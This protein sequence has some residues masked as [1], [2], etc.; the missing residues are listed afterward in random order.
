MWDGLRRDSIRP[1]ERPGTQCDQRPDLHWHR[2]WQWPEPTWVSGLLPQRDLTFCRLRL[3]LHL[4]TRLPKT[5][6]RETGSQTLT[7]DKDSRRQAAFS[8]P[9]TTRLPDFRRPGP[10]TGSLTRPRRQRPGNRTHCTGETTHS[11]TTRTTSLDQGQTI[12]DNTPWT[13]RPTSVTAIT[14]RCFNPPIVLVRKFLDLQT[15]SHSNINDL[16]IQTWEQTL[17]T[18]GPE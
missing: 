4:P 1:W 5:S 12:E 8:S 18:M 11:V 10:R 9:V 15:F 14:Y 13:R 2:L 17:Q 6:E 16:W 7:Q 3:S